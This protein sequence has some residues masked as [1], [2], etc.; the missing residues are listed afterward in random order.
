MD[1]KCSV[2]GGW[3]PNTDGYVVNNHGDR[4]RPPTGVMGPLPF[5][6]VSKAYKWG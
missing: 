2:L 6:A 3:A 4:F 1:P 5:M